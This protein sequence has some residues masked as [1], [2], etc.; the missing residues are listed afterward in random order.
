M[1]WVPELFSEPVLERVEESSRDQQP[2]VPFFA[3]LLTGEI[4]ALVGSFAGEPEIHLPLRGRVKGEAAFRRWVRETSEWFERRGA[5][6]EPVYLTL[7]ERRGCEET[8]LRLDAGRGAIA[9]PVAVVSDHADGRKLDELRVYYSN[10]R[11][12]GGHQRRAPL[13]QS[14]P[15]LRAPDVVGPYL[16]ALARGDAGALVGSFEP[17]GYAREPAG[18]EFVYSGEA[19]LRAFYEIVFSNGGGVGLEHCG[20]VDDGVAWALEYN[21]LRWGR[22]ELP[23]Q[24]GVAVYVR[25]PRGRLA[26]ARVYDDVDVPIAR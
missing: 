8:L 9:L 5:S 18:G 17:D 19:E 24:A 7:T 26:A 13:L 11:L 3:G 20:A 12:A 6:V 23:P 4:D 15:D 1:P 25:G 14:A 2:I 22:T 21:V 16:D 10:W